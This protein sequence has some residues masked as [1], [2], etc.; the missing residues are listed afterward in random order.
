MLSSYR[1]FLDFIASDEMTAAFI[2]QWRMWVGFAIL[3]RQRT[4]GK[5]TTLVGRIDGGGY[6]ALDRNGFALVAGV[7]DRHSGNQGLGIGVKGVL[8]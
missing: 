6:A 2:L 5:E 1:Y 4:T 3:I 8:Q 7:R